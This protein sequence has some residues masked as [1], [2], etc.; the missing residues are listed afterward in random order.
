MRPARGTALLLAG[1]S[2]LALSACDIPAT[3]VV[4]AGGPATGIP[5]TVPIY[6]TRDDALVAVPRRLA[7][8][9]EPGTA[10][11]ALLQGPSPQ[12]RRKGLSSDLERQPGA[13]RPTP[14][15]TES[16]AQGAEGEWKWPAEG[17]GQGARVRT[18]SDRVYVELPHYPGP[19]SPLAADQVICTAARAYLLVRRD[20]DSTT[21][22][23]TDATGRTVRGS[24]E[25]CPD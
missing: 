25:G 22:T 2:A 24:D 14:P 4:E 23:V 15:P 8:A 17:E 21:V 10:V 19:L 11:E 9:G 13:A 12:E 7:D 3:G 5:A 20:L 16:S 18:R 1:A 6:L